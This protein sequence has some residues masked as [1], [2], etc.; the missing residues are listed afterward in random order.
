MSR[1][2]EKPKGYYC[3]FLLKKPKDGKGKPERVPCHYKHIPRSMPVK[4]RKELCVFCWFLRL[5]SHF[6]QQNKL[7]Q[8]LID[9]IK[10]KVVIA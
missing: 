2:G 6:V 8:Q 1:K 3:P 9:L 4:K 5:D 7:I 10:T